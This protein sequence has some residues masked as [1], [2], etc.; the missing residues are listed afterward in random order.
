MEPKREIKTSRTSSS[1][2]EFRIENSQLKC[3]SKGLE[4]YILQPNSSLEE[5]H[6]LSYAMILE[7][8]DPTKPKK[9]IVPDADSLYS[10][11][12][13]LLSKAGSLARIKLFVEQTLS[14]IQSLMGKSAPQIVRKGF[15]INPASEK[16]AFTTFDLRPFTNEII[17]K[18]LNQLD[19]MQLVKQ[20]VI[21]D[22]PLLALQFLQKIS[23]DKEPLNHKTL[24]ML[25][26]FIEKDQLGTG[27]EAALKI[28][29]IMK[30][31]NALKKHKALTKGL[32]QSLNDLLLKHG[33]TVLAAG[34]KIPADLQLTNGE[35]V[36]LAAIAKKRDPDFYTKHLQHYYIAEGE[37]IDL[38]SPSPAGREDLF[39][40]SLSQWKDT[41]VIQDISSRIDKLERDLQ[42]LTE[43]DDAHQIPRLAEGQEISL[44]FTFK[45]VKDLFTEKAADLPELKL[46]LGN[47][48]LTSCEKQALDQF[49]NDVDKFRAKESERP[50]HII[51][52]SRRSLNRFISK[53]V[54]PKKFH[55]EK[56]E[57]LLRNGSMQ[58]F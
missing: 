32:R 19:L 39:E 52:A 12:K 16:I 53:Q 2:L 50:R 54:L 30:I 4:G 33:K 43:A 10:T 9:L 40:S 29:L 1:W 5:K 35:R 46:P 24:K 45:D 34:R 7:H 20:A 56:Q 42:P 38:G 17:G 27:A 14:A 31:K 23:L 8:P 37:T 55:Y 36:H 18:Q 41:R 11:T 44:L 47:S 13:K 49:Q 22:Q 48:P 28:K 15:E 21:T 6:G 25:S 58:T 51:K 57:A 3:T 26:E